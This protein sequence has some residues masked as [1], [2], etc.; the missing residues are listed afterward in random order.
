MH[1]IIPATAPLRLFGKLDPVVE[2]RP[3]GVIVV[4][5]AK[6]LPHYSASLVDRLEHWAKVTPHRTFLAE[7]DGEGGWRTLTYGAA[8]EQILHIGAALLA[9]DLSEEE[10]VLILSGNGIDHALLSLAGMAVG[11]PT[12]P[13]ST[14]YST[15][16]QDL[17]KLTFALDLLTP[18]LVFA[19]N[20]RV[21]G[22]ALQKVK[23]R[24][25]EIVVSDD[26]ADE[27]GATHFSSLQERPISSAVVSARTQVGPD[28]IAKFLLTSGS[29]GFPKAVTNTQR[30][31]CANQAMLAEALAFLKD[32]PP[33]LVDW[34][35]WAHTFG[36]NHNFGIALYNGGTLY[37]DEGK[38]VAEGIGATIANLRE[39]A[40]TIYFNV[41][42][43][44]EALLPHLEDDIALRRHFF[45]RL[46]LLF[47]AGA[48][49]SKPVWDAYRELAIETVGRPVVFTTSLGSTETSPGALI[50]VR[51]AD[52]PG[53]VGVPH[54]GVELK[55]V[56]N[57]GKLEARLRGPNITPGYWRRPDLTQTVFDSEGFYLMGDA[58]RLAEPNNFAAGFEFD[59]RVAEDFKLATGTWVS[60]GPLRV[61]FIGKFDPLVRDAVVTGHDRDD[62]GMLVFPDEAATRK[63]A[64]HLEPDTPFAEVVVDQVVKD[65]FQERLAAI[66]RT[67]TGSSTRVTRIALLAEPA[68][69]D[70]GESTDKG[71]LNQRAVLANR[72]K[73]VE[74]LYA[75]EIKPHI[76]R[77]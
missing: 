50:G 14:A 59:G 52:R 65:A 5:S 12:C 62:V 46:K 9:R 66:A 7:R 25:I 36:S 72:A 74:A 23:E 18:R 2:S 47:Y 8:F 15:I 49:L 30:M 44:F 57:A 28:T 40:P 31:L 6:P 37:I 26:T 41:P 43:G 71:S 35:P 69:I 58:L 16:S 3:D 53:I 60:V 42:K 70:L 33:V 27:L 55:L 51:D 17:G 29:T 22:R 77:L 21:F 19:S 48:G 45:S 56:P 68:S 20:G 34:L 54:K 67:A 10:P 13:M 4:R 64:P 76:I 32:E 24:G 1:A 38:P 39:I 73:D 61:D 11:V 75:A 63:L